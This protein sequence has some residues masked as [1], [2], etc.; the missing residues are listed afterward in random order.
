MG[1]YHHLKVHTQNG[2]TDVGGYSKGGSKQSWFFAFSP[3]EYVNNLEEMIGKDKDFAVKVGYKTTVAKAVSR[4]SKVNSLIP[5]VNG[6]LM[7]HQDKNFLQMAYEEV[8]ELLNRLKQFNEQDILFLDQRDGSFYSVIFDEKNPNSIVGLEDFWYQ[9]TSGE[10]G[11]QMYRWKLEHINLNEVIQSFIANIPNKE[12]DRFFDYLLD[13]VAE[14]ERGGGPDRASNFILEYDKDPCNNPH[15]FFSIAA[16]HFAK[17]YNVDVHNEFGYC[18]TGSPMSIEL[19]NTL[20]S[21]EY[22]IMGTLDMIKKY[23]QN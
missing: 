8:Y 1:I 15:K 6:H 23:H 12:M 16:W 3:T 21:L 4:L 22:L 2:S 17:E 13:E 20:N 9:N 10:M 11:N 7:M 14:S 18:E 19:M 5:K